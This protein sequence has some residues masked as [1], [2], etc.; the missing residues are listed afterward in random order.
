MIRS[1]HII[2]EVLEDE[3]FDQPLGT[4]SGAGVIFGA[5]G[6][7]M[8]AALR[9]GLL[10]GHRRKPRPGCLPGCAGHRRLERGCASSINGTRKLRV[11]V[12]SGLG[13]ARRLVEALRTRHR[14]TTTLSR[15]WPARAAAP[16]AAGSPSTTARSWP[17]CG[18]KSSMGWTGSPPSVSPTKTRSSNGCTANTWELP[19]R[20]GPTICCTPIIQLGKCLWLPA[21]GRAKI[22]PPSSA[23]K[24]SRSRLCSLFHLYI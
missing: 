1:E 15:S 3:A 5:T 20:K 8:E 9:S 16:A 12:A 21:T 24:H 22:D 2:P 4:A 23:K 14:S 19:F 17:R 6:G 10:P 11:A 18:A 7:V 13:N